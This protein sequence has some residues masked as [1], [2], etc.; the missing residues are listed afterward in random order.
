MKLFESSV[1]WI[2][3]WKLKFPLFFN[4]LS[5]QGEVSIITQKTLNQYYIKK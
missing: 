5:P 2:K 3:R 1:A 4:N